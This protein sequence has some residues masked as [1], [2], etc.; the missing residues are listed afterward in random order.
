MQKQENMY[1]DL[2]IP[3]VCA[4]M[5]ADLSVR[6]VNE[7]GIFRIAGRFGEIERIRELVDSG[8]DVD[9]SEHKSIHDVAGL[10]K[11]F[12]RELPTPLLT[13]EVFDTIIANESKDCI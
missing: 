10:F 9:F 4:D 13:Y 7:E 3:K 5:L 8:V 11:K 6:G 1:P 12:L 2:K